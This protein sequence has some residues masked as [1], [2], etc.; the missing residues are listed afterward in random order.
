MAFSFY[1]ALQIVY[2]AL[3][4]GFMTIVLPGIILYP[5]VKEL[6]GPVRVM[7]YVAA[8]NFYMM[9]AAALLSLVHISRPWLQ[10][11]ILIV[12]LVIILPYSR[13]YSI[14][15][16]AEQILEY[17]RRILLGVLGVKTFFRNIYL[18]I[19]KALKDAWHWFIDNIISHI[20][21]WA[22]LGAI[23]ALGVYALGSNQFIN[24]GYTSTDV[25]VHQ[26]WINAMSLDHTIYAY[27]IYPMG[28]HCVIYYLHSVFGL[29]TTSLLRHFAVIQFV[30][31][32][33]MMTCFLL[34]VSR[35]RFAAFIGPLAFVSIELW[36]QNA[37]WRYTTALPQ[38]YGIIF[39]FPTLYFLMEFFRSKRREIADEKGRTTYTQRR[40]Q[41][42]FEDEA[43]KKLLRDKKLAREQSRRQSEKTLGASQIK[44]FRAQQRLEEKEIARREKEELKRIRARQR[45]LDKEEEKYLRRNTKRQRRSHD[46]KQLFDSSFVILLIFAACFS[47]T[48]SAHFYVTIFVIVAMLG[49]CLFEFF[50]VLRP[51]VFGRLI[52][53]VIM[54]LFFAIYPMAIAYAAGTPLQGS[55][56]WALEIMGIDTPDDDSGDEE[57]SGDAVSDASGDA[58]GDASKDDS[59]DAAYEYDAGEYD[60]QTQTRILT[61]EHILGIFDDAEEYDQEDIDELKD[62]L[63]DIAKKQAAHEEKYGYTT[64]QMEAYYRYAYGDEVADAYASGNEDEKEL[65]DLIEAAEESKEASIEEKLKE[66]PDALAAQIGNL[67]EKLPAAA[68]Y[69]LKY[70]IFAANESYEGSYM[71]EHFSIGPMAIALIVLF[72]IGFI[73]SI[74]DRE[75]GRL[76]MGIAFAIF[77]LLL[78]LSAPMIGW[79]AVIEDYRVA[80]FLCVYICMGLP[81]I[82]DGIIYILT[83]WATKNTAAKVMGFLALGAVT[84]FGYVNHMLPEPFERVAQEMNE[85][86]VCQES[87]RNN[88]EDMTWTILSAGDEGVMMADYGLHT[89]VIDMLTKIEDWNSRMYY[90]IPTRTV[91]VFV[92][93]VP[94]DYNYYEYEN[95]GQRISEEL[96]A[97][98]LPEY[99]KESLSCYQMLNRAIVMSKLYY[100]ANTIMDMYPNNVRVYFEDDDFICYKITQD[101]NS[102][103]NLAVDYGFNED[104]DNED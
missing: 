63:D 79:K 20:L 72:V 28:F 50:L 23:V 17:I 88:D 49:I 81:F 33:I 8:G 85:A 32:V 68:Q 29:A 13:G 66:L 70:F 5:R 60:D 41:R 80:V 77:A 14:K 100:W 83:C 42:R 56:Y 75:Y 94:I 38:E 22:I 9:N 87:I 54:G 73:T 18:Q 67:K 35:S 76:V 6:A 24:Y 59:K 2:I 91:Y 19:L 15:Q 97:M 96:A 82:A 58:S 11:L 51:R 99:K 95:S 10:R 39:L 98:E 52:L 69:Y 25:V 31:I 30:T 71:Y 53:G 78:M 92:E 46:L 90:Y 55:L 86:I 65:S 93:K 74:F 27:G 45:S 104:M 43:D 102:L 26:R 3:A 84:S 16:C 44:K 7:I 64:S 47:M 48:I 103:I 101:T 12:V 1:N 89:E 40:D 21:Q 36:S 61:I 57:E 34:A 62:T 37:F 4:Y